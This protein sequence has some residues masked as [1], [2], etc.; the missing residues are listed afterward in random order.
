MVTAFE[1]GHIGPHEYLGALNPFQIVARP[2]ATGIPFGSM[3]GGRPFFMNPELWQWIGW[4]GGQSIQFI[5]NRNCG[6]TAAAKILSYRMARLQ[7]GNTGHRVRPSTDDT[8]ANAGTGEYLSW[9]HALE[10]EYTDLSKY[11]LNVVDPRMGMAVKEQT[12]IMRS[13]LR[14]SSGDLSPS[15]RLVLRTATA[16]ANIEAGDDVTHN[17]I[18]IVASSMSFEEH[19]KY[20]RQ[21]RR[22]RGKW[23]ELHAGDNEGIRRRLDDFSNISSK[24]FVRAA[25][26]LTEKFEI[27]AEEYGE[28]FGG[29]HSM[30]DLMAKPVVALDFTS[31]DEDTLAL[32]EMIFWMWRNAAIRRHDHNLMA[33]YEIHDENWKRWQSKEWGRNMIAHLKKI[34]G[35]GVAVIKNLHRPSDVLQVG[36]DSSVERGQAITG[37]RE[38]DI[39]MVGQTPR[40]EFPELLKYVRIPQ[41]KLDRLPTAASGEFVV[42]IGEQPAFTIRLDDVTSREWEFIET[43]QA[44]NE[45]MGS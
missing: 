39:W 36:S 6:K 10:G 16:V 25:Q 19:L 15:E 34:R 26:R 44:L 3:E 2:S 22:E 9:A 33:H 28:V 11:S 8:R 18:G 23:L 43:N 1:F 7:V 4:T 32:S 29:K 21:A 12:F 42:I 17:D 24:Q 38:T 27:L 40:S 13:M 31:L 37:L 45:R 41:D 20:L 35:S 5:G 14:M 30:Y